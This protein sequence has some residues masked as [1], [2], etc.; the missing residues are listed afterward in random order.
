[1]SIFKNNNI[2]NPFGVP[3]T[4]NPDF[5]GFVE[6]YL[7][8]EDAKRVA[9]LLGEGGEQNPS[10]PDIDLESVMSDKEKEILEAVEKERL[11][12]LKRIIAWA[13][14]YKLGDEDWVETY[15][16][17]NDDGSVVC[18]T[19]LSLT[20]VIESD[21]P[22]II[23]YVRGSLFLDIGFLASVEG[24][25]LPDEI[26][27]NLLLIIGLTSAKGLKLPGKIGG[28]LSL[29]N[30]TSTEGLELPE[31]IGGNLSLNGLTSAKGLKLPDKIGRDLSL[32]KLTSA[33]GLELPKE[34]IGNLSLNSLTSVEGLKLPDKIGWNLSLNKLTSAVGLEL[35]E[36]IGKSL[37][38]NGLTSVEGLELPDKIGT[39]LSLN[40]LTSAK[41][42]K[43]PKKIVDLSLNGL[44]SAKGLKLPKKIEGDLYLNGLTL[45]KDLKLTNIKIKGYIHLDKIPYYEKQKLRKK[46]PD[47]KIV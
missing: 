34:I 5:H 31:E 6:A 24:L 9:K 35:P 38:L 7:S 33:E 28:D 27:G 23:K 42:L 46:Y 22:E 26:E 20:F 41:G 18:N 25:E 3:N 17:F 43:L 13:K 44:T 15:F 10:T 16:E 19:D 32:N 29:N 39:H 30:L 8:E 1:M 37:S 14:K 21:F 11:D 4:G 40:G 2:N 36:E 12:P 45:T 47:L